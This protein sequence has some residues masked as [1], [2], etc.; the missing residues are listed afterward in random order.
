[1][2][3][4]IFVC[5]A[6]STFANCV[7]ELLLVKIHQLETVVCVAYRPPNTAIGEFTGLLKC[8][9]DTLSALPAPTPTIVLM[10]DFNFNSKCIEWNYWY[11]LLETIVSV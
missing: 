3:I 11:P 5:L 2:T 10:G 9:D 1:M 4:K 7:C 6:I 8:L